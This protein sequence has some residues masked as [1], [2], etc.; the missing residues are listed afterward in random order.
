MSWPLPPDEFFVE[1]ANNFTYHLVTN[2]HHVAENFQ[3]EFL[4]TADIVANRFQER[5]IPLAEK[6]SVDFLNQLLA[7]AENA[8][9]DFQQQI[10]GMLWAALIEV[11]VWFL[12]GVALIILGQCAVVGLSYTILKSMNKDRK[13]RVI[14][15]T[16]EHE[17]RMQELAGLTS[18][19]NEVDKVY[20]AEKK[21]EAE[22][23]DGADERNVEAERSDEVEGNYQAEER[24]ER[25]DTFG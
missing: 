4:T 18:R 10:A 15:M 7:L 22:R 6:H 9:H 14:Q 12:L 19:M 23:E 13:L 20:A 1:I 17:V 21:N 25:S 24:T 5:F 16:K 2:M 3:P 11:G 8:T